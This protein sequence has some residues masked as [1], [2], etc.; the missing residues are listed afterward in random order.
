MSKRDDLVGFM[1][2]VNP[3][4]H[5]P[6][7]TKVAEAWA[8]K[9]EATFGELYSPERRGV[10]SD[11]E[12]ASVTP[13]ATTAEARER[14]IDGF[15]FDTWVVS[16]DQIG[17]DF[18]RWLASVKSQAAAEALDEVLQKLPYIDRAGDVWDAASGQYMT[19]SDWLRV[20]AQARRDEAGR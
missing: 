13:L 8:D 5:E 14:F 16:R 3:I 12:S 19:V 1:R 18:D 4:L 15:P 17:Q 10:V 11:W 7:A 2:L 6:W 20:Q 9:F